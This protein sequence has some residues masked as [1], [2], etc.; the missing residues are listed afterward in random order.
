MIRA[1]FGFTIDK[2]YD[3]GK[4]YGINFKFD[5]NTTIAGNRHRMLTKSVFN[6]RYNLGN[7]I[8]IFCE[9][10]YEPGFEHRL[11]VTARAG[12]PIEGGFAK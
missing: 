5:R 6:V 2:P 8:L 1:F 9:N 10:N 12:K 4:N 11:H 7:R 3:Q